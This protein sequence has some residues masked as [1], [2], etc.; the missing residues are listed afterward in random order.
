MVNS[1]LTNP[2]SLTAESHF[3]SKKRRHRDLPRIS[4]YLYMYVYIYTFIYIIY[5]YNTYNIYIYN[6]YIYV[7]EHTLQGYAKALQVCKVSQ[8]MTCG[9]C[10]GFGTARPRCSLI[11]HAAKRVFEVECIYIYI[12]IYIYIYIY[13]H[14]YMAIYIYIYIHIYIYRCFHGNGKSIHILKCVCKMLINVFLHGNLNVNCRF[15]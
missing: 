9:S 7:Y 11:C 4:M 15:I 2:C 1:S 13:I 6:I 12:H 10:G 3:T 8:S 14:T 5:I